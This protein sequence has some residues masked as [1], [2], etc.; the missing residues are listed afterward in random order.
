MGFKLLHT[1]ELTHKKYS[2]EEVA[3][4]T[5]K[6][7]QRIFN[8]VFSGNQAA[9]TQELIKALA[10]GKK[11]KNLPK[12][13]YLKS[14]QVR[15]NA[16][17]TLKKEELTLLNHQAEIVHRIKSDN[18]TLDA[19]KPKKTLELIQKLYPFSNEEEKKRYFEE[20]KKLYLSL[21][22]KLIGLVCASRLEKKGHLWGQ[23]PSLPLRPKAEEKKEVEDSTP[24]ISHPEPCQNSNF[25]ES[26]SGGI[27]KDEYRQLG[28]DATHLVMASQGGR[29][30][31][32]HMTQGPRS[33]SAVV[34]G[35]SEEVSNKLAEGVFSKI[36]K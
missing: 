29:A 26:S 20:E 34:A 10:K 2:P 15:Q 3:Y 16:Y 9:F 14:K 22:A 23:N 18:K 8:L 5:A 24:A 25:S 28:E 27:A 32:S 13:T 6:Y 1:K 4:Y 35:A 11:K 19:E 17:S 33:Q 7:G 12:F 31:V 21:S 36:P 30:T